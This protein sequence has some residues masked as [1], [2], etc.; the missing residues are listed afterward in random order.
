MLL[1]PDQWEQLSEYYTEN[2]GR[3]T[4]PV[5]DM[6]RYANNNGHM[7]YGAIMKAMEATALA[8]RP[9]AYYLQAV[10]QRAI[11]DSIETEEDWRIAELEYKAN[12][13]Q[14]WYEPSRYER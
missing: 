4:R 7:T 11:G 6:I 1:S 8:P 3:F 2:I 10:L 5:I 13:R 9:T 12:S 14:R